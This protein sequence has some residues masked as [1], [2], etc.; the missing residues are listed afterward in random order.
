MPSRWI[1]RPHRRHHD[2]EL[3][4]QRQAHGDAGHDPPV[5]VRDPAERGDDEQGRDDDHRM[6]PPRDPEPLRV[7]HVGGDAAHG[8][9]LPARSRFLT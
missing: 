2:Q 5:A 9:V 8:R 6:D 7:G 1:R 4:P 3:E